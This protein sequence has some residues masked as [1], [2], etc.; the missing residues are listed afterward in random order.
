MKKLD[1]NPNREMLK[2][3]LRGI[4]PLTNP[5]RFYE[6]SRIHF[7]PGQMW[8]RWLAVSPD[9][10]GRFA[11]KESKEDPALFYCQSSHEAD[12]KFNTGVEQ[13]QAITW[14]QVLE[15]SRQYSTCRVELTCE[16]SRYGQTIAWQKKEK[17]WT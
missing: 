17:V 13:Y 9:Q 12:G 1:T 7:R 5:E 16:W 6:H 14:Q 2:A 11:E 15:L 8:S 3:V 4:H 10:A